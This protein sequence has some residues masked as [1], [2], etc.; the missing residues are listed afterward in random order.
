MNRTAL[1]IW[2]RAD[3]DATSTTCYS[4]SAP[5]VEG[6][7]YRS[8]KYR[9][10]RLQHH[11]WT[12]AIL[13]NVYLAPGSNHQSPKQEISLAGSPFAV[14]TTPTDP[15]DNAPRKHEKS[16]QEYYHCI[17]VRGEP[18]LRRCRG[19]RNHKNRCLCSI[20]RPWLDRRHRFLCP[21]D[22]EAPR[23]AS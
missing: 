14:T 23:V 4:A 10:A 20:R 3:S 13:S 9:A 7:L 2:S 12:A 17:L 15:G 11:R 18:C 19:S 8:R 16:D 1:W 21:R 5:K 22:Q 6:T